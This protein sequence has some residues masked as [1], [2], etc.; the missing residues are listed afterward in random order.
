MLKPGFQGALFALTDHFSVPFDQLAQ[1]YNL[2]HLS[3]ASSGQLAEGKTRLKPG[4]W[5]DL[6]LSWDCRK[7]FCRVI[8]DGMSVDILPL[9]RETEKVCYLRL[10]STAT[11]PDEGLLI[12]SVEVSVPN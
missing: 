2:F 8:L 3:V 7:R 5:Y 6:Q 1:F 10:L 9:L 12:E 11:Q 4:R